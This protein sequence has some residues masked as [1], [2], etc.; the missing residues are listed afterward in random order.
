[1]V[2]SHWCRGNEVKPREVKL[3]HD[4]VNLD[5]RRDEAYLLA[6]RRG[7]RRGGASKRTLGR[8]VAVDAR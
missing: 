2:R 8:Q 5:H 4:E 1:M 3:N 6:D 7:A